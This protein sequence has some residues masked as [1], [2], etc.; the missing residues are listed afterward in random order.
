MLIP[1]HAH[2]F[3]KAAFTSFGKARCL[4]KSALDVTLHSLKDS[5]RKKKK[6]GI[7]SKGSDFSLTQWDNF[8][9][10]QQTDSV[11][12]PSKSMTCLVHFL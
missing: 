4:E 6:K 8:P 1:T 2:D 11:N 9:M 10:A 7:K 5:D 12:P 3:N